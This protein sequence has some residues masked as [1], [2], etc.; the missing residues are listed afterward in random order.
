MSGA[1]E[2]YER[3]LAALLRRAYVPQL[4][5]AE[6]RARVHALAEQRCAAFGAQARRKRGVVLPS[7]VRPWALAAGLLALLGAGAWLALE[8]L[9]SSAAPRTESEGIARESQPE[10]A[11]PR[12]DPA[13]P[14]ARLAQRAPQAGE[15]QAAFGAQREPLEQPVPEPGS[16]PDAQADAQATPGADGAPRAELRGTVRTAASG[17]PIEALELV[18]LREVELPRVSQ[19]EFHALAAPGGEFALADLQAGTYR[20]FARADGLATVRLG[21][22]QLPLPAAEDGSPAR[23]AFELPAG[24]ALRGRIVRAEDGEPI[25]G[26]LV[27]SE[28]DCP[29]QVIGVRPA[30]LNVRSARAVRSAADGSFALRALG[31]GPQRVRAL[32]EGR[33]PALS[34][35]VELA[36]G[37]QLELEPLAMNAG[38]RISGQVHDESGRPQPGAFV[39]ASQMSV[40]TELERMA[41]DYALADEQGRYRI[42]HLPAGEWILL[43]ADRPELL[44]QG[45]LRAMRPVSLPAL[46]EARVDFG[47]DRLSSLSGR[48]FGAD[49]RP[50]GPLALMVQPVDAVG[51]R[52]WISA[53]V[54][55][56]GRYALQAVRPGRYLVYAGK[57]LGPNFTK[58]DEVLVPASGALEHDLHLSELHLVGRVLAAGAGATDSPPRAVVVLERRLADGRAEFAGRDMATGNGSYRFDFLAA[59]HY[60]VSAYALGDELAAQRSA[61]TEVRAGAQPPQ[62]DFALERGGQIAVRVLS[63]DGSPLAGA[64]VHLIAPDGEL[65]EFTEDSLTDARGELRANAQAGS[66]EGWIEHAGR[67]SERQRGQVEVGQTLELQWSWPSAPPSPR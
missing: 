48:V 21:P 2:V 53:G 47:T 46:G 26:A 1:P 61:W 32:A 28:V 39:L 55:A 7:G 14:D 43:L 9:G 16:R 23:L 6:L 58:V 24:G 22:L 65:M 52:D 57:R 67:T 63:A 5:S 8:R 11:A 50:L 19:P 12:T 4:P 49:G 34:A 20:I 3:N 64:R 56:E 13:A 33:A 45:E 59:G 66:W 42:E 25:A 37:A 35:V 27:F 18:L 15:D 54:D 17:A 41:Y 40:A 36:D 30:E 29:E 51:A 38:A 44:S 10:Q 60:R 62:V 31:I